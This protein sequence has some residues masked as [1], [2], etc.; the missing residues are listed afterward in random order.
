MAI[1]TYL[2]LS[3]V[4]SAAEG[5]WQGCQDVWGENPVRG[6]RLERYCRKVRNA[7]SERARGMSE[8]DIL[9]SAEI[10]D[11]NRLYDH[12][13]IA[14]CRNSGIDPY[15]CGWFHWDS[16]LL[17]QERRQQLLRRKPGT[18]PPQFT[19]PPAHCVPSA[20]MLAIETS[21]RLALPPAR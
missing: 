7:I 21:P 10:E 14:N 1:G 3:L 18:I 19:V 2:V 15:R 4:A 12:A 11:L 16:R 17:T 13:M 6:Y 20:H 9:L 5:I 8:E